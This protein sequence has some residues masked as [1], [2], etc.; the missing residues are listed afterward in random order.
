MKKIP[1][2]EIY[3]TAKE[4]KRINDFTK[5]IASANPGEKLIECKVKGRP[6]VHHIPDIIK[7]LQNYEK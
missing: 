7:K 3:I 2:I 4:L 5:M 6:N 1:Q